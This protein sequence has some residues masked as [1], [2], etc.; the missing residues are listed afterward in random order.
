VCWVSMS[1]DSRVIDRF[2]EGDEVRTLWID[3]V[4][5]EGSHFYVNSTYSCCEQ[6]SRYVD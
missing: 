5:K 1:I 4:R 3:L 2:H 6:G